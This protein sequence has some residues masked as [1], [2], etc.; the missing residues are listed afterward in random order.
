MNVKKYIFQNKTV[1]VFDPGNCG[2]DMISEVIDS[3][4]NSRGL[5]GGISGNTT[6]NEED[7]SKASF[8]NITWEKQQ[9]AKYLAFRM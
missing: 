7:F 1:N 8:Q 6:I 2:A 3:E 5:S 4:C 9:S